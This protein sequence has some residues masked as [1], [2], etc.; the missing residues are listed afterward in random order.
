[1]TEEIEFETVTVKVPKKIMDF[2][3]ESKVLDST[4]EE[5]LAYSIVESVRADMDGGVFLDPKALA[6]VS[7]LNPIFKALVNDEI[8]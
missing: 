4:P 6:D 1:M 5:Y 8:V 3:R 7:G 2:L